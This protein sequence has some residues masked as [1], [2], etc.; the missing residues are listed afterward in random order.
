VDFNALSYGALHNLWF[1]FDQININ[2]RRTLL[3]TD[4]LVS[5]C[6]FL[7]QSASDGQNIEKNEILVCLLYKACV[8]FVCAAN[9]ALE[10]AIHAAMKVRCLQQFIR[11]CFG[12]KLD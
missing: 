1:Y 5:T 8:S 6:A 2:P 7:T 9:E 12:L 11:V 3:Q 10:N 4:G